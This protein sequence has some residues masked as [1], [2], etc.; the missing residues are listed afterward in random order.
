MPTAAPRPC[1]HPRCAALVEGGGYC[2]QHAR[3]NDRAYDQGR[4]KHEPALA[5]AARIRSSPRWRRIRVASRHR[6]PIC[7][8]PFN[9]ACRRPTDQINHI[10]PIELRPDLAYLESNHAP[11]C[12]ACHAQVSAIER[13]RESTVALFTDWLA[14]YPYALRQ[15]RACSTPSCFTNPV[16]LGGRGES[17]LWVKRP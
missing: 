9:T 7:C 13:R 1:P 16:S 3:P 5:M 4:R 12:T 17:D 11:V 8:D 2:D 6:W 14:R 15:E 10:Q